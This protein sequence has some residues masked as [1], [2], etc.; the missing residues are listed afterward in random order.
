MHL[1]RN[2]LPD[3]MRPQKPANGTGPVTGCD[4]SRISCLTQP[5]VRD[6]F[7]RLRPDFS[8]D[9][10]RL[11]LELAELSYRLDVAPWQQAGWDD[12]SVQVDN[13][14]HSGLTFADPSDGLQTLSNQLRLTIARASMADQNPVGQI[15]GARRQKERSDTLKAVCM[16]HPREEGGYLLAIG[17]MG[18]GRRLLDWFSN[19]RI[20]TEEGF[21][22]GFYQLSTHFEN[23]MDK[24]VFPATARALG[25]ES[26]TLRQVMEEMRSMSSRF[27][28][29]MAGHSQGS[30]VMQVFTHRLIYHYGVLPQNMTGYGFASP[31]VATG[32][33][34]Y[35][36]A[37]YPLCHILN[38][39]DIVPK[40]GA[41]VHLGLG[42]EY[43]SNSALREAAY[44]TRPDPAVLERLQP[45]LSGMKDG[46]STMERG[47]AV[48]KALHEMADEAPPAD[49]RG[50]QA[51]LDQAMNYAGK[52]AA[53]WLD[54]AILYLERSYRDMTGA[55]MPDS[56]FLLLAEVRRIAREFP[57][58]SL[59]EAAGDVAL[60]PHHITYRGKDGAYAHIVKQGLAD[61]KPFIWVKEPGRLP[62][63]RY[64][65]PLSSAQPAPASRRPRRSP[66]RVRHRGKSSFLFG[67]KRKEAK[68]KPQF[69]G[70][71]P[72]EERQS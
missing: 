47:W 66:R 30:A 65:Q 59:L 50:I 7:Y 49:R 63:R 15:I 46:P 67:S 51:L 25:L 35:D 16:M 60:P 37:C 29:W 14:L 31:T 34:V 58:R 4:L 48:L 43:A 41:L 32:R 1:P 62:Q 9:A 64:A 26:L 72:G 6:A 45:F 57:L 70:R 8:E 12:F 5:F 61:L 38:S 22:K 18:T 54:A 42:L 10:A 36:P 2:L 39:D 17:F 28:L 33:L 44:P 11:S 3:W 19:L 52:T 71:S 69:A 27:R 55:A 23:S 40:V 56:R 24:I 13:T 68:E 53:G 20:T 21:H